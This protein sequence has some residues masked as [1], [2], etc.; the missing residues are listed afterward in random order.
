MLKNSAQQQPVISTEDVQSGDIL[1]SKVIDDDLLSSHEEHDDL[2]TLEPKSTSMPKVDKHQ[3]EP[4]EK[5]S[6]VEDS[7]TEDY[8]T[9]NKIYS[10]EVEKTSNKREDNVETSHN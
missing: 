1:Q 10:Q 5:P 3:M 9:K 8:S 7:K 6:H 2:L 4:N